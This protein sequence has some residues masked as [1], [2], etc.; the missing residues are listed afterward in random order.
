LLALLRIACR[1]T[2]IAVAA[3]HAQTE[4]VTGKKIRQPGEY[5]FPEIHESAHP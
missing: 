4:F 3:L 1:T 5:G 2:L